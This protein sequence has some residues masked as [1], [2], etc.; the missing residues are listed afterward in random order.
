MTLDAHRELE[1][2]HEA[3]ER[4]SANLVE[5]EIDSSRQLLEASRL[6]GK[7]AERW[8]ATSAALTELW[9]RNALLEELLA[10][11]DKL[12]G[13]R[14]SGELQALL[15]GASI[16]LSSAAVPLAQRELLGGA[17]VAERCSPRQLLAS[18]SAA[19]DEVKTVVAQIGGAW[20]TLVPE[21]D[22]ARRLLQECR[23]LTE[24]LGESARRDLESADQTLNRL[25]SA[26]TADPLSV[27]VDEIHG[28]VETLRG[29]RDDLQDSLA[30]KRGFES[31]TLAARSLLE[32]LRTV[33]GQAQAA[34]EELLLKISIPSPPPAPEPHA[35]LDLELARITELAGH[36]AWAEASRS[37]KDWTA[38]AEG[39][40]AEGRRALDANRAPIE[41]RNQLRGLLDAYQVK[42]KRL[43]VLEQPELQ[44][45]FA[46]AQ[47]ALYTAPSDLSVAAQLVRGYQTALAG[48]Q[49]VPEA[50]P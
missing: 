16:E 22:A 41:A 33:V 24:E 48:S 26:V 8:S 10:Q 35:E 38:R 23:R 40:L 32:Q 3:A 15:E 27:E 20:E 25:A 11:A 7:S 42:A 21:L 39:L 29:I 12:R 46:R 28:T 47:D 50:T 49:S 2:L 30:L 9:R 6:E 45:I 37:L 1:L 17:Q 13:G 34:H 43:G 14:H 44:E 31:R 36:G 19:F 4:I 18:M 5:L